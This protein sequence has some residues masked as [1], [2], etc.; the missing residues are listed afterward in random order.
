MIH[1]AKYPLA[2]VSKVLEVIGEDTLGGYDI[3]CTAEVTVKNSSLGPEFIRKNSH[4]CVNAFHG[5]THSHSCQLLYHPNV[6]KGMGIE[7]L[8]TLERLFSS[9][10]RLAPV[11]RYTSPFRRRLMIETFL[12]QSDEDKH[13]NMGTFLASNY[14]Q[15][16]NIIRDGSIALQKSMAFH[17]ITVEEMTQWEHEE[18]E[19]FATLGEEAPYDIHAVAYVEL[20]QKLCALDKKKSESVTRFLSYNPQDGV[21]D[22][23]KSASITRRLETDRRHAAEQHDRTLLEICELEVKL[24][25][26]QRWTP[27]TPEYQDAVQYLGERKYQHALNKLHRLVVQRL[28]ELQKLNVAQTGA[29]RSNTAPGTDPHDLLR[30]QDAHTSVKVAPSPMQNHQEG[31]HTVQRGCNRP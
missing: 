13:L 2:I 16:T 4:F 14:V 30:L 28:F 22:Y 9:T 31:D 17:N 3:G 20:L 21:P 6:I 19:Y 25:V 7:D 18:I 24:N 11:T 10:N 27:L 26:R 15:A 12:K 1:S 29:F 5:Y 23:A 8:E